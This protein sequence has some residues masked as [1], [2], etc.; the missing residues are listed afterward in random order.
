MVSW[1]CFEDILTLAQDLRYQ[2]VT[3]VCNK[4]SLTYNSVILASLS[5]VIRNALSNVPFT[6]FDENITIIF[7]DIDIEGIRQLI[8][9]IVHRTEEIIMCKT[10]FDFLGQ[11]KVEVESDIK[12]KNNFKEETLF[13]NY[14]YDSEENKD[15][16]HELQSKP[17]TYVEGSEN[18]DDLID[19]CDPL[20]ESEIETHQDSKSG[21]GE[22]QIEINKP[23]TGNIQKPCPNCG[24]KFHPASLT[25]HM[26]QCMGIKL[27]ENGRSQ[28]KKTY[29]CE[30][31]S[32][33]TY[34]PGNFKRHLRI[35]HR[36]KTGFKKCE[37][38]KLLM[39]E[40]EYEGHK[41][42]MF[43]CEI[44][45][46]EYGTQWYRDFHIESVHGKTNYHACETCGKLV[47]KGGMKYHVE[48]F[49][50]PNKKTP[51]HLCGKVF[52]SDYQ[53]KRHIRDHSREKELCTICNKE[54]NSLH[55][56]MKAVHTKEEDKKYQC[57]DCGRGFLSMHN[58]KTHQMNIHIKSRPYKCRYGCTFAYND[59]SNRDAHERK[60]HG[61]KF[62]EED[63]DESDS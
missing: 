51:C 10:V 61:K 46:K 31:C 24:K 30:M 44:C 28:M 54:V 43:P 53:L 40:A 26:R 29:I 12:P 14:N 19:E 59:P 7:E 1:T 18:L 57:Q 33:T 25:R 42:V 20:S 16:H 13:N 34:L 5:P 23:K 27:K 63:K 38:C 55:R 49:H 22:I 32:Y 58:L 21:L 6:D 41:C 11:L 36:D 17:I 4:E 52:R 37:K 2:D 3:L 35:V 15:R 45:G 60:K 8:Y 9:S 62:E 50:L 39:N 56:H 47:S 48:R